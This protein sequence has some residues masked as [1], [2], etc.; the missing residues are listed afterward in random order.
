MPLRKTMMIEDSRGCAQTMTF[1]H[2]E[3]LARSLDHNTAT[4]NKLLRRGLRVVVAEVE[5]VRAATVVDVVEVEELGVEAA[6]DRLM[7]RT[8]EV[9]L[10]AMARTTWC[11]SPTKGVTGCYSNVIGCMR[12]MSR[13]SL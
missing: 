8:R 5:E 12:G 11:T 1:H 4:G 10:V 6:T 2:L 9:A 13:A 7:M 3:R